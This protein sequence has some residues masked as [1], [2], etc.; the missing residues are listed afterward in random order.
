MQA[1]VKQSIPGFVPAGR[2]LNPGS[3]TLLWGADPSH[4]EVA[5]WSREE[6]NL[7]RYRWVDGLTGEVYIQ[8]GYGRHHR[9]SEERIL[10][11][12]HGTRYIIMYGKSPAASSPGAFYYA[13]AQPIMVGWIQERIKTIQ[14]LPESPEKVGILNSLSDQLDHWRGGYHG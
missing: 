5:E 8:Q 9:L 2:K 3:C 7:H 11:D 13:L 1:S 4:Q 14:Q 10:A 12:Q 6:I